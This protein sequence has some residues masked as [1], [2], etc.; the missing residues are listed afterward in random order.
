MGAQ[1]IN[2]PQNQQRY[3]LKPEIR[4]IDPSKAPAGGINLQPFTPAAGNDPRINKAMQNVGNMQKANVDAFNANI[5][6]QQQKVV[7][8]ENQ[9]IRAA[10][11]TTIKNHQD[12]QAR[13]A[14][15]YKREFNP[16][17]ARNKFSTP[18]A[19]DYSQYN[20]APPKF[21]SGSSFA[22]SIANTK[23]AQAKYKA[24][25]PNPFSSELF[26]DKTTNM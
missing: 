6:Q 4:N 15:K 5:A 25:N 26:T 2:S 18:E 21:N 20:S 11:E 24:K 7:D 9:K 23:T 8:A 14:A 13:A 3:Q 10:N 12:G 16:E 19:I 1:N 17:A 22:N